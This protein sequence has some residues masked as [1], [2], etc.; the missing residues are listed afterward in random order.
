MILVGLATPGRRRQAAGAGW[1]WGWPRVPDPEGRRRA[2]W[3]DGREGGDRATAGPPQ[4]GQRLRGRAHRRSESEGAGESAPVPRPI[5]RPA[6]AEGGGELRFAP[7]EQAA[8]EVRPGG[9][10]GCLIRTGQA[11]IETFSQ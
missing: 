6:V 8:D 2:A 11:P 7:A 10:K 1:G 3:R 4:P 9:A 5:G